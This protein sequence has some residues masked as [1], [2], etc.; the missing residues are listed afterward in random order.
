LY[1]LQ[2]GSHFLLA[3]IAVAVLIS[4]GYLLHYD[5]PANNMARIYVPMILISHYTIL[6]SALW[7]VTFLPLLIISPKPKISISI[8]AAVFC[9]AAALLLVDVNLFSANQYH[10]NALTARILGPTTWVFG[11][12]FLLIFFVFEFLIG[13]AIVG[14]AK[15]GIPGGPAIAAAVFICTISAQAIH[16]W[17]DGNYY[18]PITSFDRFLPGIKP[19]TGESFLTKYNLV[20]YNQARERA[21]AKRLGNTVK[22]PLSYPK[23]P[24]ECTAPENRY[25]VIMILADTLRAD[26]MTASLMPRTYAASRGMQQFAE[27][28][29]GGI[30]T[31]PGLFS[32]FYSLPGTYWTTVQSGQISPVLMDKFID[33]NYGIGVFSTHDLYKV[34]LDRTAFAKVSAIEP[35]SDSAGE[36]EWSRDA[37]TVANWKRWLAETDQNKPFFGTV[38]LNSIAKYSAPAD[39]LPSPEA[40]N[41]LPKKEKYKSAVR[42][43]DDLIGEVVDSLIES[44]KWHN[45]I[46]IITS[47]HGEEFDDSGLGYWG[48][49]K[50]YNRWQLHVPL[51]VHWP[52]KEPK[53][54][55]NRTSHLD[56][57]PTLIESLFGC[58]NDSTDY[59]SGK[60]LFNGSDWEWII[61]GSYHNIALIEPDQVT[62]SYKGSFEVRDADYRVVENPVL[63]LDTLTRALQQT[64]TF[65]QGIE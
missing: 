12:V 9:I 6:A 39:Y 2:W 61:A 48:H 47:D 53:L 43:V 8:A 28:F 58:T 55:S 23:R 3:N 60:N 16:I 54:F 17:A 38:M 7:I 65:Y 30:A 46:V 25:N 11:G 26:M 50:A 57:V 41:S 1:L 45:S 62:T 56:V 44:D 49:G 35:A 4:L 31:R 37:V 64:K 20:D 14:R 19:F 52:N 32:L 15:A 27:H 21:L 34:E 10:L 63:R 59:S 36:P 18:V 51:L 13:S 5:L 33:E 24:L 40:N 29:S 22:S 42:Y